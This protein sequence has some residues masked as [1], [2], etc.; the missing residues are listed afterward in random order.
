M[1]ENQK[2]IKYGNKGNFYIKCHLKDYLEIEF[3]ACK[4]EQMP[5]D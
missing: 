2:K 5:Q 4:G 1:F 3:T